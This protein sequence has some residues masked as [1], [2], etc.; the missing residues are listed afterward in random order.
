V[1][2]HPRSKSTVGMKT[3]RPYGVSY[4]GRRGLH[5]RTL[6]SNIDAEEDACTNIVVNVEDSFLDVLSCDLLIGVCFVLDA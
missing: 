1:A 3:E 5:R 2:V 4:C 6:Y